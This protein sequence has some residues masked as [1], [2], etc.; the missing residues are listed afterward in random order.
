VLEDSLEEKSI[1]DHLGD[2]RTCLVRALL[3][4]AVAYLGC[5]A[6][7]EPLWGWVHAP[8]VAVAER[9]QAK[10]V[11]LD[12]GEEFSILYL[13]TPLVA[14][15]FIA[16]P[17]VVYQAW[18][19]IA[20]GL[21]PRERRFAIP[22]MLCTAGLFIGGGL[23]GY[24]VALPSSLIFL[25]GLGHQLQIERFVR[26]DSYFTSF[27]T[28]VLGSALSFE[29]PVV[30]FFLTLV[31]LMSPAFL[32]R[33]FRYAIIG[34]FVLA[35]GVTPSTN[36]VDM[37]MIGVPMVGLFFLGVF[38][39]HLLVLKREGLRFPWKAFFIWIGSILLIIGALIAVAVLQYGYNLVPY[40][41]FLTK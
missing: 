39:S 20:P 38:A 34:I 22:F 32:L 7:A 9:I 36:P 29:L 28:V 18:S 35:A 17:W 19:F 25:L 41:P 37:A 3:G 31:R 6:L 40:S 15:L 4:F 33:N 1:L 10:E 23:F 13:W 5:V 26:I 27:V 8:L 12:V 16:A 21:Y 2:L 14:S 24:Y 11:A 30:V